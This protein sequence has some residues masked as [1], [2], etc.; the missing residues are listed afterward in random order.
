MP[1]PKTKAF[2]GSEFC[3]DLGRKVNL[4]VKKHTLQSLTQLTEECQGKNT[5][6]PEQSLND[7]MESYSKGSKTVK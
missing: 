5:A 6:R 4:E 3:S 2:A 1:G 7:L